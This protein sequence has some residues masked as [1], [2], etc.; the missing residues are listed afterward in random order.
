MTHPEFM[1]DQPRTH[2]VP[3]GALWVF[4]NDKCDWHV[5]TKAQ[6]AAYEAKMAEWK[7]YTA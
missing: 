5:A 2:R 7:E 1:A 6:L 4:D 3:G